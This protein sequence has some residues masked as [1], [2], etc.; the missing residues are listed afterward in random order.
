MKPD[1]LENLIDRVLREHGAAL[2][3]YA[4]TWTRSP[5]DCVQQALIKLSVAEPLPDNLTAWLY[6]V[7]RN[8]AISMARSERRRRRREQQAAGQAGLFTPNFESELAVDELAA[9]LSALATE[10]REVVVAKIWGGLTF[11]EIAD[12]AGCSSSAA[13]RRYQSGLEQLKEKL[14]RQLELESE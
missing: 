4:A 12:T 6:R 10:I 8:E 1:Q 14:T 11:A 3:L 13:H 2:R 9:A 7:V 5:D